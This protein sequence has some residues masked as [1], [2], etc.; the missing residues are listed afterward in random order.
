MRKT[1]AFFLIFFLLVFFFSSNK[2]FAQGEANIWYFG[3]GAG[4][5]FNSGT[6][7]AITD[8][9]LNTVEGCASISNSSGSLLFYTNGA[10]VWN[11]Q[12]QPMPNGTGLMGDSSSTQAAVIVP[13]PGSQSIY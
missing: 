4:L 12:H 13:K 2:L 11:K 5:D 10:T 7:I 8:G 6:P 3:H 1:I 9:A